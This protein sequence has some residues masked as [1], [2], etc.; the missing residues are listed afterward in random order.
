MSSIKILD[1]GYVSARTRT[2]KTQL[3]NANRA[4]Y[5]GSNVTAFDVGSPGNTRYSLKFNTDANPVLE[6]DDNYDTSF[7][8]KNNDMISF[9]VIM[10]RGA[11]TSGY[12]TTQLNEFARLGKTKG[13]K[14]LY[15]SNDSS[16]LPGV[17][18]NL[19][20]ENING[21]FSA[22][23]PNEGNGTVSN[24]TPYIVG[25]FIDIAISDDANN[26][27]NFIISCTFEVI[28]ER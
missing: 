24:S 17:I 14:L 12:N 4:G 1:T 27:S 3:S 5:T 13:V 9:S 25:R 26:K 21:H 2:G 20:Y 8:S 28:D 11:I 7:I 15:P 22:G 23:S 18:E 6:N 10:P 16:T 19:G